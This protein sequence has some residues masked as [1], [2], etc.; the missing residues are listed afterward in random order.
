VNFGHDAID[1][2]H[3]AYRRDEMWGKMKDWLR[4]GGV[5]DTDPGLAADLAK[6]ML[7]SDQKQRIK[8]E[9]KE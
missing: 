7:V 2:I 8:L 1:S 5:I 9:S 6:P 4:D 3:Y